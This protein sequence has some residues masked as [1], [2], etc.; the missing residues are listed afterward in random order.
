MGCTSN[1]GIVITFDMKE[2]SGDPI[3]KKPI[4]RA[5]RKAVDVTGTEIKMQIRAAT[6]AARLGA[7]FSYSWQADLYPKRTSG[8]DGEALAY[9]PVYQVWNNSS[10]VMLS[11]VKG[12]TISAKDKY[13]AVPTKEVM[14]K[15][16]RFGLTFN[17]RR[18]AKD[19][20]PRR[21]GRFAREID[22]QTYRKK[23]GHDLAVSKGK[24]SALCLRDK[25]TGEVVFF[26][27]KLIRLGNNRYDIGSV[28]SRAES[29][30]EGNFKVELRRGY[31]I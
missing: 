24:G 13:M 20:I 29:K 23:T 19:P 7:R 9:R 5:M 25:V 8:S 11:Q 1:G 18:D 28:F 14:K 31:N 22:P 4:L 10:N 26:L 30:L 27:R 3:N 12:I 17:E 2:P 21:Y 16:R 6:V 15:Y